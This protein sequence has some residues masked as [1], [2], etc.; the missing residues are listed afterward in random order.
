MLFYDKNA[1]INN[2]RID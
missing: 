2:N 1:Y